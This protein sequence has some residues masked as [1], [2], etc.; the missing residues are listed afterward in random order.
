MLVCHFCGAEC[1]LF[2]SVAVL[3]LRT[4][5]LFWVLHWWS[6]QWSMGSVGPDFKCPWCGRVNNGGYALDSVGYPLCVGGSHGCV[7]YQVMKQNLTTRRQ[8]QTRALEVVLTIRRPHQ[9]SDYSRYPKGWNY[10]VVYNVCY[11]LS[12]EK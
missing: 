11:F 9:Q 8:Y 3:V 10:E 4:L 2:I 1:W 7:D 5:R 12:G 6:I